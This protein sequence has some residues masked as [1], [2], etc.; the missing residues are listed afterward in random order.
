MFA[1]G[2][3]G[4]DERAGVGAGQQLGGNAAGQI[5]AAARQPVQ[6]EVAGEGAITFEPQAQGV[7]GE[8]VIAGQRGAADLFRLRPPRGL[9]SGRGRPPKKA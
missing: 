1:L 6:G 5:D 2:E 7:T 8:R 3:K 4:L 9:P